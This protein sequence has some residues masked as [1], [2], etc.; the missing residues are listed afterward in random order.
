[1]MVLNSYTD[2]F[3]PYFKLSFK[4]IIDIRRRCLILIEINTEKSLNQIFVL[5]T[6]FVNPTYFLLLIY[7]KYQ[8]TYKILGCLMNIDLKHFIPCSLE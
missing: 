7:Y 4:I 5:A 3:I 8:G 6:N 1:M 2:R